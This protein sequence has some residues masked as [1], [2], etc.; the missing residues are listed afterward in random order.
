MA[1]NI[2]ITPGSGATYAADEVTDGTLG[3]VKVGF[4]KI[5]DGTLDGTNKLTI[6]AGGAALVDGSAVTQPVSG[7]VSVTGVSTA[8]NQTTANSSLSSIDTKLTDGTQKVIAAGDVASAAT[9]SGNPVKVG[10]VYRATP[11]TLTDGQRGD[12]T[13]DTRQNLK[14]TLM[15]NNSTTAMKNSA[16]NAD[17]AATSSTSNWLGVL[18][19]NTVYNG[20][21]WD[22]MYGDATNGVDVDVTRV[23][24]GT[25]ATNLGKAEDAAHTSGD[26]GVMSLGVRNDAMAALSGTDGDYTPIAT[27]KSG[28][29]LVTPAPSSAMVRGN[30]SVAGTGDTSLVAASGSGGLKTYITNLSFA[31]TGSSNT[32]ITVKDG[33]GGSTLFYT[34]APAGG[35]SNIELDIPIVTTANTA[36]YFA[37]GTSSTTVYASATGYLAP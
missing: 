34:I 12:L 18:N 33:S 23:V 27:S 17:A 16:D 10:G 22:R 28:R 29:L 35:G 36:L 9:D 19:R 7:T 32:L 1:D 4:T 3:S 5:M 24:P 6:S 2:S 20:T 11:S 15:P 14:I 26:V 31:N 21:T 13:T 8:A 25:G 37:C 30:A